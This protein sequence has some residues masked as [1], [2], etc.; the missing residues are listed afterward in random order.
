[1]SKRKVRRA[2]PKEPVAYEWGFEIERPAPRK[3][4]TKLF[5]QALIRMGN[6]VTVSWVPKD[7]TN[8]IESYDRI[9]CYRCEDCHR[10]H[11]LD[12]TACS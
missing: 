1:M 3:T 4:P 2:H 11:S 8:V 9:L 5:K 7:T 10:L 6:G 12:V